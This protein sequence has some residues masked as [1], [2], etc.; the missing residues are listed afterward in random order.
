[1]HALNA[2]HEP[3]RGGSAA[4]PQE[5]LL[6]GSW[7]DPTGF[8]RLLSR[9]FTAARVPCWDASLCAGLLLLGMLAS[10]LP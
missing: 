4:H 9:L 5:S 7:R 3:P 10:R 1:M 2:V 8:S 6:G